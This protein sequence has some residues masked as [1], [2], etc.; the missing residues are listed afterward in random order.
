MDCNSILTSLKTEIETEIQPGVDPYK[1][2][3]AKVMRGI[4]GHDAELERPFIGIA[5]DKTEVDEEM[6]D[7]TGT[8]SI[9]RMSVIVYC[10]MYP[11]PLGNYDDMYQL[12]ADLK[13]FFKYHFS[14]KGNTFVKRLSPIE[15]GVEGSVT[16]F[17]MEIEILY[18][19]NI[20]GI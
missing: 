14:H 20:G 4:H 2:S 11:M 12:A 10:Y 5:M 13:Y 7:T 6:F 18:Q 16:Y 17:D 1:S 3:I 8:D 19:E 9:W 15:S